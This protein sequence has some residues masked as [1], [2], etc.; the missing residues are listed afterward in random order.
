MG[1]ARIDP[2][3][4]IRWPS[5]SWVQK[6]TNS[7]F[8]DIFDMR[9]KYT[10]VI[11]EGGEEY[12]NCYLAEFPGDRN[13]YKLP[14]QKFSRWGG[15]LDGGYETIPNEIRAEYL[16]IIQTIKFSSYINK[17]VEEF[18]THFNEHTVGIQIRSWPECKPPTSYCND[19]H[20]IFDLK[21]FEHAMAES[22]S[23]ADQYPTNF[24]VSCDDPMLTEQL[25]NKFGNH[26]I[27]F[28]N[29][30]ENGHFVGERLDMRN[31]MC[32]LLL[33]SKCNKLL[34]SPYSTFSEIAWWFGGA[35]ADVQIIGKSL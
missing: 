19:R 31:W 7:S 23:D 30:H 22:L 6:N 34:V 32:D 33:L 25:K 5:S 9:E 27:L 10:D 20:R 14:R 29:E 18:S 21:Y 16:S 13:L 11:P 2:N 4:M 24:F 17:N 15:Y 1:A 3:Y 35:S 28:K 26:I 12:R 8:L